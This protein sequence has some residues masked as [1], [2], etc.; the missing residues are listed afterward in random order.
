MV[1]PACAVGRIGS[2]GAWIGF[3]PT[4]DEGYALTLATPDGAYRDAATP[5]DLAALALAW[6]EES[7]PEPPEALS[8][9]LGDIGAIVRHAA[10]RTDDVDRRREYVLAVDAIDDGLA[11]DVVIDRLSRALGD[12]LD[13]VVLLRR[14]ADEMRLGS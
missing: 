1:V 10:D 9:T 13:P 5:A 7:L 2:D 12:G 6:F 11:A 14:R 8:A 4:V 3:A